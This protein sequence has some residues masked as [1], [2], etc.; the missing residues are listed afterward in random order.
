MIELLTPE[1]FVGVAVALVG[2]LGSVLV[3]RQNAQAN[4]K[5]TISQRFDTLLDAQGAEITRLS[6]EVKELRTDFKKEQ[7]LTEEL[8][9]ESSKWRS[10]LQVALTYLRRLHQW[11][12]AG[13]PPPPPQMPP[14]LVAKL[15]EDL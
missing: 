3:A 10:L 4:E 9:E 13:A 1:F 2:A 5:Q 11:E 15:W 14:E 8:K 7:Q 12:S 6:A